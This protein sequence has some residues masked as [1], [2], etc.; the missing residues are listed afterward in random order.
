MNKILWFILSTLFIVQIVSAV[1]NHITLK[2]NSETTIT[3]GALLLSDLA[4]IVGVS[5]SDDEAVITLRNIEL[6]SDINPG[7]T[8]EYSGEELLSKLRSNGVDL[9]SIRYNIPK[10]IKVTRAF[11]KL[12]DGEIKKILEDY[13]LGTGRDVAVRRIFTLTPPNVSPDADNFS[14]TPARDD[15]RS[16]R[17]TFFVRSTN[18]DAE[19]MRFSISADLDEWKEIPLAT[20]NI[21]R[22]EIISPSDLQVQRVAARTVA[23]D[24]IADYSKIVGLEAMRTIGSG[25]SF[26]FSSIAIPPLIKRG[27]KVTMLHKTP[28]FEITASGFALEDGIDGQMIKIRNE[29]SNKV[30]VGKVSDNGLILVNQ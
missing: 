26:R 18:L 1:D 25:D 24:V 22:G 2:A 19:E 6:I 16:G 8:I 29:V 3:K 20:R 14:V 5:P 27:A 7:D 17:S 12:Q 28:I 13:L 21:S 15:I 23:T 10:T 11:R 30:V 4:E 9:T